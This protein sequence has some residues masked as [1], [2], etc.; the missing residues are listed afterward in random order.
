MLKQLQKALGMGDKTAEA[1]EKVEPTA[2]TETLEVRLN[3]EEI[4]AA[5]DAAVAELRAEFDSYKETAEA[6]VAQAEE[7]AASL[8]AQLAEANAKLNAAT[9]ALT[10]AAAEKAA[11][12]AEA[13]AQKLAARKEKVV[14]AI[15]TERA[16]ALLKVTENM[17]DAAFEAVVSALGVSAETEANSALFKEVG[18]S[19]EADASQVVESA[20]MRILK[21]KYGKK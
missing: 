5:I 6:M 15:G 19:G 20:E 16:D 13:L 2:S 18:A 3:T 7:Q 11:A 21:Q 10:V 1:Q 8:S 9:E 17:D 12:E 4:Q 14:A